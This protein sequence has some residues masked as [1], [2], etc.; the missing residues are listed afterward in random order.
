MVCWRKTFEECLKVICP[1]RS[2]RTGNH[3]Q[4]TIVPHEKSLAF[5]TA[6]SDEFCSL[7]TLLKTHISFPLVML[8]ETSNAWLPWLQINRALRALLQRWLGMCEVNQV[9]CERGEVCVY[10]QT[11]FLSAL[12]HATPELTLADWSCAIL[13]F[14]WCIDPVC[15]A[16]LLSTMRVI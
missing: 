2:I 5:F 10:Y 1:Y 13:G 3:S 8:R 7:H 12:N 6:R 14:L 9:S 4:R 15:S 11:H 16:V